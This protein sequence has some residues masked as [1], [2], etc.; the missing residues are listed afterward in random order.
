MLTQSLE[1][2][3]DSGIQLFILSRRWQMTLLQSDSL[4]VFNCNNSGRSDSR[5]RW[6]QEICWYMSSLAVG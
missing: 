5:W 1:V 2:Q 6:L 4:G 3:V